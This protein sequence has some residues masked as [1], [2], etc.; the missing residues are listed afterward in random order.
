MGLCLKLDLNE[1]TTITHTGRY[2]Y[3]FFVAELQLFTSLSVSFSINHSD[4][5]TGWKG[6][7]GGYT[8]YSTHKSDMDIIMDVHSVS[9]EHKMIPT[10]TYQNEQ[11]RYAGNAC[12]RKIKFSTFIPFQ[13]HWSV[14]SINPG[15]Q[16]F[17]DKTNQWDLIK[18]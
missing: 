14:F 17:L 13:S 6:L 10:I 11:R 9:L 8:V 7:A 12:L 1:I 16:K 5:T 4:T 2:V 3:V 18:I 15:K